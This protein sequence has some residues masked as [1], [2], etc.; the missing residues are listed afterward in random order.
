MAGAPRDTTLEPYCAFQRGA[1]R[2]FAAREYHTEIIDA[3]LD[4]GRCEPVSAMGRGALFTFP[5]PPGKG[6]LREYR[7]GG[8]MQRFLREGTM[9]N[10]PSREWAVLHHLLDAGFP[11]PEPLGVVW[12]RRGLLY[13]GAIATRFL[14]AKN[15]AEYLGGPAEVSR[16][17]LEQ[18]GRLIRRMHDLGVFHTDLNAGNV[19]IAA[20][21]A[22]QVPI[23]FIDFDNAR[24]SAMTQFDRA[25]NLLRLRRSFL[26]QGLR[27]TDFESILRGY[28][29]IALP[30]WL[31]FVY[32]IKGAVS[33]VIQ[34]RSGTDAA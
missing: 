29:G 21:P 13:T 20:D 7:R 12:R 23:H 22:A 28:G 19:L 24:F 26:K 33:D 17:L 2:G 34:R 32:E 10:R 15:L 6:V 8:F 31:E 18:V 30:G 27:M 25:R 4:R 11:A 14:D 9:S 5:A 1:E 16:A 3:L